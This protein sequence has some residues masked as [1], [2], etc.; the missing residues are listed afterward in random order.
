[1]SMFCREE[2]TIELPAPLLWSLLT[3]IRARPLWQPTVLSA[4]RESGHGF[5]VGASI[6][7]SVQE[8]RAEHSIL[9]H[10]RHCRAGESISM[11]QSWPHHKIRNRFILQALSPARTKLTLQKRY[12]GK[13]RF[14][15]V[16]KHWTRRQLE[17]ATSDE[18]TGLA[19]LATQI[20]QRMGD[21]P[22]PSP[23][24]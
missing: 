9:E 6:R 11:T 1:M 10:I 7:L 12:T 3:D 21:G 16:G 4:T 2:T 24:P 18:L 14:V 23:N 13:R 19:K 15:W 17:L 5:E 20:Q 8:R 22:L